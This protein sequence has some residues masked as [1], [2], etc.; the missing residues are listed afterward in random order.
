M[1]VVGI[2]LAGGSGSRLYPVTKY[3]SKHLLP[4]YN[5]PMIYYPLSV[6]VS[7]GIKNVLIITNPPDLKI[8]RKVLGQGTKLGVSIKYLVQKKPSGIAEAFVIGKNFI[9]KN[10][11]ALIL[12]DNVFFGKNFIFKLKKASKMKESVIFLKKVNN[13]ERFGVAYLNRNKEIIKIK[14]KPKSP[15]SNYAV[16]G[17]YFYSND[18][19][20][21]AKK[22]KPSKRGELEITDINNIYLKLKK[23][24]NFILDKNFIWKDA[25]TFDSL[26]D[27][28]VLIKKHYSK[29]NNT[30]LLC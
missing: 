5:K 10:R 19:I 9:K 27:I 11:V 17:L 13:P 3:V 24:K 20:N 6:L 2:I 28:S 25:G 18:V 23:L 8:Y 15:K 21:F 16:T 22:L 29:R 26:L 12:G 7:A 14:E 4:I 30:S 1:G